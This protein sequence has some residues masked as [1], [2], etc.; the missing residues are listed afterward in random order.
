M[1][2]SASVDVISRVSSVATNDRLRGLLLLAAI[3]S[4]IHTGCRS[5]APV[6]PVSPGKPTDEISTSQSP[7]NAQE[8]LVPAE[9]ECP[10]RFTSMLEASGIRFVHTS[11]NSP[12][13][14]FPAANGSGLATF[15]YDLDGQYDLYFA[16]GTTFPIDQ[17]RRSQ[18]DCFW[19]NLRNWSFADVTAVSGLQTAGYS[20]GL[21]TGDFNSDG[22]PDLYVT[23][24]GRNQLYCNLGDGTFEEVSAESR[25][26]DGRLATSAAFLDYD[27]D[28]LP[29]LYVCHY[30]QWSFEN[31]QFCGDPVRRIRMFCSPTLI[32]PENDVLFHNQGD[33]TFEDVSESTGITA[34]TARGQGVLAAD[35]NADSHTD[36]YVANDINPNFL[37]LN[38]G[39][40]HFTE[41]A[42]SSGTAYDHLG[43]AQAG[44]G[45]ALADIDRNGHLDLFVTN[46]QNEHNALYENFG[47]G[48]FMETG[49]TR[50]PEGSLPFVGWGTSLADF[51]L[52]GWQDLIVTNGH[53]DDNLAELG[54]EGVYLQPCRVWR[55][56][57]GRF[58]LLNSGAGAY[59][60]ELHC[61]RGL[62]TAD[63][64]NDG[65]PDVVIGHQDNQ[66]GLLR[67]DR[68]PSGPGD[69]LQVTLIGRQCNRD[70]VGAAV[71][72][73]SVRPPQLQTVFG[74]GSYAS[75]S[76][77]RLI[78][79]LQ[80]QAS[81]LSLAIRWPGGSQSVAVGLKAGAA[82]TILQPVAPDTAARFFRM[83]D[84]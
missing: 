51:D 76:D 41:H 52:D 25:T 11:G 81:E 53:T 77:R 13:K 80:P 79:G 73:V 40:G 35:L 68:N 21:A 9:P 67:N 4:A 61:G 31:N 42:E 29:D 74:G 30:G 19:R 70:A 38:D 66:P 63:L 33:G 15:D 46:Y 6:G 65:D 17:S 2:G 55:N 39:R 54:K 10:I 26:D 1:P 49:T 3:V 84:N 16:N 24:V 7:K 62:L 59:F 72:I 82:Y 47:N 22:F 28:G 37:F 56:Q 71:E 75:A 27:N 34:R 32:P 43:R 23:G 60:N 78:F 12:E 69:Y 50:V 44:M 18:T 8:S 20:A 57:E 5:E 58:K 48:I 14:P 36:L 45:L 83:C 64:D